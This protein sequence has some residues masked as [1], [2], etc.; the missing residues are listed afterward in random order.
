MPRCCKNVRGEDPWAEQLRKEREQRRLLRG[1]TRENK[2]L[3]E[4]NEKLIHELE[5]MRSE[6]R[7]AEIRLYEEQ[8]AHDSAEDQADEWKRKYIW[9]DEWKERYRLTAIQRERFVFRLHMYCVGCIMAFIFCLYRQVDIE[10][11]DKRELRVKIS[12][13]ERRI[14]ELE[15]ELAVVKLRVSELE[16]GENE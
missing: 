11:E 12:E 5:E 10:I 8:V 2:L 4:E 7:K 3:R 1:Q 15:S 9:A 14:R 6:L 13:L 16:M